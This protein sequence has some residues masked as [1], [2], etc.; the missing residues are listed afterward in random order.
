MEVTCSSRTLA[1]LQWITWHYIPER[2]NSLWER[3]ACQIEWACVGVGP[4]SVTTH[5][6][7]I[8]E[9]FTVTYS[10]LFVVYIIHAF[11][12]P[13]YT[14]LLNK[15]NHS[16]LV[17][18]GGLVRTLAILTSILCGFPQSLQA[19]AGIVH[20]LDHNCFLPDSSCSSFMLYSLDTES[21]KKKRPFKSGVLVSCCVS[22]LK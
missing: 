9:K 3:Q 10:C 11:D 16:R 13:D 4:Q 7:N 22:Y 6:V 14:G 1:D 2:Q 21:F 8:S 17:F 5:H 18:R 15:R 12:A 19:Y 20:W